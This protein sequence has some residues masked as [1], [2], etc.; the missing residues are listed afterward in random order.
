M[1]IK[2]NVVNIK[3]NGSE[4]TGFTFNS[5]C[6]KKSLVITSKHSVCD[7][8]LNCNKLE[9][10]KNSC[11]T[12]LYKSEL[13][14]ININRKGNSYTI[15]DLHISEQSDIALLEIDKNDY[16]NLEL[17][18]DNNIQEYFFWYDSGDKRLL[19]NS[20]D[21]PENGLIK[22][23]IKSN[24]TVNLLTKEDELKGTSGSL[25][26]KNSNNNFF[27][28]AIITEDGE[29]NDIGAEILDSKLINEFN[30]LANVNLFG[31]KSIETYT[32]NALEKLLEQSQKMSK[33]DIEYKQ[34]LDTLKNFLTPR[35]VRNIIGLEAKLI[36]GERKDL[37]E[38]AM[39]L[40][41]LF[42][43]KISSNQ[44]S[45]TEEVISFHCLSKISSVFRQIVKPA[46]KEGK[47]NLEVDKLIYINIVSPIY[48][49][50]STVSVSYN[51]D[52]LSG[53][54]YFLTGKCHLRW[55]K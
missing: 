32:K 38:D 42:A 8:R 39:Y 37:I 28:M 34:M 43:R 31:K 13:L 50:I 55:K 15:E 22:Y 10:D 9:I 52:I 41:N 26:F 53:M 45:M 25:V 36:E 17:L 16:L 14:S 24:T 23:N 7:K 47:S 49:E 44:F 35:P 30:I 21:I 20:P 27:P 54:L 12:C 33:E 48:D 2:D 4:S 3:C 5:Y 19:I 6:N 29:M 1:N 46:I 11:R 40:S 51:H 18:D